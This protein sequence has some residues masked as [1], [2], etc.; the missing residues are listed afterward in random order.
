MKKLRTNTMHIILYTGWEI[1]IN[2][3]S[4]SFEIHTPSH[5]LCTYEDPAL[6]PAHTTHWVISLF[7]RHTS[8]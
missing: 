3:F 5:D 4:D 7:V 1:I 8:V 2:D 6:P